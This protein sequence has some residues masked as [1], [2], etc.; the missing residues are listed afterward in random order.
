MAPVYAAGVTGVFPIM[1]LDNQ[2]VENTFY[3]TGVDSGGDGALEALAQT[4][5]EWWTENAGLYSDQCA[6]L[7]VYVRDMSG[8]DAPMV[9][10]APEGTLD[11]TRDSPLLPNNATLAIKRQTGLQGRRNRGRIYWCGLTEDELNGPNIVIANTGT[12]MATQLDELRLA[13]LSDN[14]ATEVI[15]HRA[16]GTH[17]PVTQY[18]C[19]DF[20]VDSQRRRLPGHNRHH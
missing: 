17:T 13:Q 1:S 4:Y 12:T 11:G 18:V 2:R 5:I 10:I 16:D 6:L 19:T 14:A 7:L 9:E 8:P 15:L 20:I 3:Y